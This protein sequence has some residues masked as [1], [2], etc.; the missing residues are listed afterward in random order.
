M[1]DKINKI[2]QMLKEIGSGYRTDD[3]L[4]ILISWKGVI[5][6]KVDFH[7]SISL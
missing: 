3:G 4:Q 5:F 6:L 1:K 2:N 7:I